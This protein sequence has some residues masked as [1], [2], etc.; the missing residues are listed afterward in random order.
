MK[1]RV[2]APTMPHYLRPGQEQVL[3]GGWRIKKRKNKRPTAIEQQILAPVRFDAKSAA[4]SS[5]SRKNAQRRR[6]LQ[7][8]GAL[9]AMS[10]A[11]VLVMAAGI[12]KPVVVEAQPSSDMEAQSSSDM[13]ESMHVAAQNGMLNHHYMLH[14]GSYQS[15]LGAHLMWTG[16]EA[17]PA[18]MLEGLNPIFKSHERDD[19]TFIDVFVGRFSSQDEADGHCA[20]LHDKKV[21]CSVVDG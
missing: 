16:L 8:F 13:L 18:T 5:S 14:L 11:M 10:A 19:G 1:K 7:P 12:P 20:W 4:V 21:S 6:L 9:A 3:G 17:D 15:E 2:N